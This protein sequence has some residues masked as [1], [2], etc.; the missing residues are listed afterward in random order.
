MEFFKRKI[1]MSVLGIICISIPVFF[2]IYQS[3][4]F[5]LSETNDLLLNVANNV[6]YRADKTGKQITKSIDKLKEEN[7]DNPCSEKSIRMMRTIDIDSSNIQAIG[8]IENNTLLCSSL[9]AQQLEWNL[10]PVDLVTSSG[11]SVRFNVKLPDGKSTFIVI[12]KAHYATIIHKQ[13]LLE[14][15]LF[16]KEISL[17]VFSLDTPGLF[18]A[19]GFVDP[20]WFKHLDNKNQATFLQDGYAIALLKSQKFKIGTVAAKPFS[21]FNPHA[22]KTA[23][24]LVPLC[25]LAGILLTLLISY[26]VG[27]QT[28]PVA[29]LKS[30]LK[31]REFYLLYQPVFDIQNHRCIGA[32]A[33]LRWKRAN[34]KIIPPDEFIPLAEKNGLIQQITARVFEL[35]AEDAT[36]LFKTYPDFH[37]AINVSADDLHSNDIIVNLRTLIQATQAGPGNLIIEATERKLMNL[38]IFQ[39]TLYAIHSLGV[40]VAIDDFGTGYSNLAYLQTLK[41]DYLK[42]DKSFVDAI[43]TD[44]S[45]SQVI[46][47]IIEMAKALNLQIIAEGVENKEQAEFIRDKGVQFAQGWLYSKALPLSDVLL[48]IRSNNQGAS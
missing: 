37:L 31:N 20:A 36:D 24:I 3:T 19:R 27:Q 43:A 33:L 18:A 17:G 28:S 25:A 7:K 10:G 29:I 21:W 45:T 8:Y 26:V 11:V 41:M 22:I 46:F 6:I 34:G 9:K 23:L 16:N 4:K 38:D 47:H 2:A 5:G 42:I 13:L 48:L 39:Q 15:A 1:F 32:E 40:K 14:T 44:S 30:G 35:L 12:E